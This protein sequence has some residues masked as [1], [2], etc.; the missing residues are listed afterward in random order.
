MGHPVRKSTKR[1]DRP[2]LRQHSAFF[3]KWVK[4]NYH[5]M[6][7]QTAAFQAII[8]WVICQCLAFC[9]QVF[10]RESR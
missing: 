2:D 1:V 7:D 4:L 3:L 10:L 9:I 8:Y 5:I 6:F